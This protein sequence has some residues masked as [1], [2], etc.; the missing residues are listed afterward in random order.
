MS[1]LA[2]RVVVNAI[3]LL[4]AAW[5]VPNI[6]LDTGQGIEGWIKVAA[7]AFVFGLI[8]SYLAP[9]VKALALPITLL[10]LG[11]IGIVINAAM[12]LVLSV[13]ADALNLPFDVNGFPDRGLT[14]DTIVA[15]L[16]GAIIIGIVAALIS[17][18]FTG[19]RVLRGRL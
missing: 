17:V 14:A 7:I 4:V 13:A 18:V 12:L 11:L 2:V 10:T 8:N 1:T 3:T 5:I 15:A 19:S 9:I 16:I 6:N